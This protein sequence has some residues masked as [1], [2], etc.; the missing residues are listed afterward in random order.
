MATEGLANAMTMTTD[1][2]KFLAG[3]LGQTPTARAG[4][5]ARV[6]ANQ[7]NATEQTAVDELRGNKEFLDKYKKD[8]E[9]IK[10]G[11]VKEAEIAFNAIALDLGGQGFTKDAVKTYIDAL[12]EEAGKTDVSLKFKQIDLSTEEG[13]AAI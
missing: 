4:S 7:L 8:I 13:K 1:K 11:T 6:S 9:A 3:L 2:V 5:G 10:T 12:G